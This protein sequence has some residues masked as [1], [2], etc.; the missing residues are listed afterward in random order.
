M[1]KSLSLINESLTLDDEPLILVNK[2]LS[3][4]NEFLILGD[5]PLILVNKSL[6]LMN[7]SLQERSHFQ[8]GDRFVQKLFFLK[9]K[10]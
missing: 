6:S 8:I 9:M 1:N 4:I 7:E 5:E 10:I 2:S 3:L